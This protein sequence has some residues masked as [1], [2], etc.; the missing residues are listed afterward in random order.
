MNVS[1]YLNQTWAL[2]RTKDR[3]GIET[4]DTSVNDVILEYLDDTAGTRP[5]DV[6][7]VDTIYRPYYV[8]AKMLEQDGSQALSKAGDVQFTGM[9]TPI[10]SLYALQDSIDK[11][12]GTIV[13]SAM[14][15]M[16]QPK[17]KEPG[18]KTFAVPTSI[19]F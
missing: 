13:P 17:M 1:K 15:V 5:N 3:A 11:A 10:A 14:Q 18:A 4:T 8:A 2:I 6:G 16:Q 19:N 12:L 7:G 9:A